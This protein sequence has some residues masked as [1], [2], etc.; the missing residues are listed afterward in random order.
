MALIAY[1]GNTNV[2]E[3]R[4]LRNT[5]SGAYDNGAT[6]TYTLLD[7]TGASVSSG[8]MTSIAES[9][10]HGKYRA[11][12]ANT[13]VVKN[14]RRYTAVVNAVGSGGEVAQ[15]TLVVTPTERG[16]NG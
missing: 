15:W 14:N 9:P 10:N 6:V 4:G 8:A 7:S 3:L 2:L 16:I 1:V 11:V 13:V 12:I 5:L